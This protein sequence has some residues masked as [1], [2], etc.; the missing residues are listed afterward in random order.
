[1]FQ[2]RNQREGKPIGK[3]HV[4]IIVPEEAGVSTCLAGAKFQADQPQDLDAIDQL[5]PLQE[6][7]VKCYMRNISVYHL[8]ET[9]N[10]DNNYNK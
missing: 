2:G 5:C 3:S 6:D 1:M 8:E 4:N 7:H 10:K 9:S